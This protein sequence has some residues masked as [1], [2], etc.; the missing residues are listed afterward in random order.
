M[1]TFAIAGIDFYRRYLSPLKG[2][3]CA[4]HFVHGAGSCSTY[5]RQVYATRRFL[6]A[7]RLLRMR[8][9]ECKLAAQHVKRTAVWHA[10][11]SRS[12][13]DSRKRLKRK[14]DRW[15]AAADCF[16]APGDCVSFGRCGSGV[17]DAL[18]GLDFCSCAL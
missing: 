14:Q 2:F 9:L 11:H 3:K 18:S 1:S 4:H 15:S 6:D 10:D 12:D 16:T 17:S 8:F 5:G 13:E 7:T